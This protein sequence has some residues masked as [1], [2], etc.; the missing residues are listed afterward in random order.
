M[1][2]EV[3]THVD[4]K[5]K[6]FLG[7]T[8]LQIVVFIMVSAMAYV[9]FQSAVAQALGTIGR[10]AAVGVLWVSGVGCVLIEV[11]GR[12]IVSVVW[13]IVAGIMSST[14]YSGTVRLYLDE[15]ASN[16]NIAE[17]SEYQTPIAR[18]LSVFSRK[19]LK[20]G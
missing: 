6:V 10:Y 13:D 19:V 16:P 7:M 4:Q 18:L 11:G 8:F 2:Q 1:I 20:D 15:P 3:P 12:N 17:G 9:F 5:D 14:R